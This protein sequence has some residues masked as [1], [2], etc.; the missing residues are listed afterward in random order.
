MLQKYISD[1]VETGELKP[2]NTEVTA[3]CL[4]SELFM[5]HLTRDI[6]KSSPVTREEFIQEA[7]NNILRGIE[8]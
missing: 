3:R 1:R 8:K 2:H 6:F 5:F 4:F 7:L